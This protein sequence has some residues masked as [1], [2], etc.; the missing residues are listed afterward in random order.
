M[1]CRKC[2]KEILDDSNFCNFCGTRVQ[3]Q[4]EEQG[5]RALL[6]LEH[7]TITIKDCGTLDDFVL[8]AEILPIS[9]VKQIRPWVRFCARMIDIIVVS[10]FVGLLV[11]I[12]I[13]H[14]LGWQLFAIV[15]RI[16]S[17][18]LLEALLLSTWGMTLGKSLLQVYVRD[19]QGR[20]LTFSRAVKRCISALAWGLGFGIPIASLIFAYMSYDQIQEKGVAKWDIEGGSLVS[21]KKIGIPRIVVVVS[22]FIGLIWLV[23]GKI[24]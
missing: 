2:G 16:I 8:N 20:K 17:T 15:L 10:I 1:Y 22:L 7:T 23:M 4:T 5:E 24:A 21:H 18:I 13:P 9:D 12:F 19:T 3:L 14:G 11:G 6:P